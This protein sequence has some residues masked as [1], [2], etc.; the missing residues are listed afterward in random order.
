MFEWGLKNKATIAAWDDVLTYLEE[1][2]ENLI[3]H[4]WK[5]KNVDEK[6]FE[7]STFFLY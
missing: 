1:I 2:P 4:R 3:I 5:W 6:M 7:K